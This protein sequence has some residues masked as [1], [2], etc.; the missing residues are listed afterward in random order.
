MKTT[1]DISGMHPSPFLRELR[2]DA[3]LKF[4]HRMP[5]RHPQMK[6]GISILQES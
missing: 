5:R 6:P 2:R 3:L 4:S 1:L